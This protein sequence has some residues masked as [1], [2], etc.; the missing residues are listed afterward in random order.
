MNSSCLQ[1]VCEVAP[2]CLFPRHTGARAV[3]AEPQVGVSTIY[4]GR[5]YLLDPAM[6]SF[7][8]SK[9]DLFLFGGHK[10]DHLSFIPFK[11][12]LYPPF[13]WIQSGVFSC[14]KH[15]TRLTVFTTFKRADC[16]VKYVLTVVL[17]IS[18]T[19]SSCK[20]ETVP[21]KQ[22]HSAPTPYLYPQPWQPQFYFLFPWIWLFECLSLDW[23]AYRQQT[24]ISHSPGDRKSETKVLA[25]SVSFENL[26][27]GPQMADFPLCLP[28]VE[29]A[30]ELC[31]VC[32]IR[33]LIPVVRA[34]PSGPAHFPKA[35]HPNAISHWELGLH[36]WFGGI[37]TFSL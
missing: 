20:T 28:V 4:K 30:R 29:G 24:F 14:S 6:P 10:R 31:G 33:T 3:T 2:R 11:E 7:R 15:A 13:Y 35:F 27:F 26:L 5:R 23:V 22:Q 18:R 12:E 32:F 36:V 16:G 34:P 17:P 9:T 25:E 37:W 8:L 1:N 19:S 21:L